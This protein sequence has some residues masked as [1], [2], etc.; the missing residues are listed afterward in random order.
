MAV[1][2]TH[3]FSLIIGVLIQ[4]YL[5]TVVTCF[6]QRWN[7]QIK[8]T[9]EMKTDPFALNRPSFKTTSDKTDVLQ[10]IVE[11]LSGNQRQKIRTAWSLAEFIVDYCARN[12]FDS[13]NMPE[14]DHQFLEFFSRSISDVVS[15]YALPPSI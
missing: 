4:I 5:D 14:E 3:V 1:S 2:L 10:S 11:L 12:V 9:D 13:E 15:I 6:P 8:P 7:T